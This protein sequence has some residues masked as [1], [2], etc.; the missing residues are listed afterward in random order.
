MSG[1]EG[2]PL[3]WA[4][5]RIPRRELLSDFDDWHAVLNRWELH[6]RELDGDEA[7]CRI[8]AFWADRDAAS[9]G[10]ARIEAWPDPLRRRVMASWAQV[11]EIG[12]PPRVVQAVTSRFDAADVVDAVT[13]ATTRRASAT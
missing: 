8:D 10:S 7:D 4:W 12:P 3:V 1:A 11:F 13:L 5:A 2:G 9:V 6:P